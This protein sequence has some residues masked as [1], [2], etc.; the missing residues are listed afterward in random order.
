[1]TAATVVVCP[2]RLVNYRRVT[3]TLRSWALCARRGATSFY[4]HSSLPASSSIRIEHDERRRGRPSGCRPR[5]AGASTDE[6]RA[7][8]RDMLG[9]SG[10]TVECSWGWGSACSWWQECMVFVL[11]L[12]WLSWVGHSIRLPVV[13][14]F[15][16]SSYNNRQ[17]IGS[18]EL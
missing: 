18:S 5:A 9:A 7:V 11:N 17:A 8:S 14:V 12:A 10:M 15:L 3:T 1:M 6:E 13:L 16:E 2:R 4:P